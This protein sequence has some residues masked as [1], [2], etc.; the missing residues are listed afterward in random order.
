M[1]DNKI[2]IYRAKLNLTQEDLAVRTG[3]T[4]QTILA[5]EKNKYMPSLGLAF[6]IAQVFEVGIEDVFLKG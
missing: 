1:I 3:V 5:I 2:K 6:R 4:R